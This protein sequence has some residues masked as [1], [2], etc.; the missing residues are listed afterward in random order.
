MRLL[1]NCTWSKSKVTWYGPSSSASEVPLKSQKVVV[2]CLSLLIGSLTVRLYFQW[3][4]WVWKLQYEMV[5]L[6]Y[7]HCTP[8]RWVATSI[9]QLV[10][11]H[12]VWEIFC[13]SVKF[14]HEKTKHMKQN[15]TSSNN[16]AVRRATCITITTEVQ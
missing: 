13:A 5:P 7:I 12:S 14:E 11:M 8:R 4:T 6:I 15:N 9:W 2:A 10:V 1:L 16:V 3:S